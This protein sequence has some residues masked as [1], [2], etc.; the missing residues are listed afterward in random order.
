MSTNKNL[1]EEIGVSPELAQILTGHE[2]TEPTPIQEQGIPAILKGDDVLGVAKT[3]TGKTLA[4]VLPLIQMLHAKKSKNTATVLI[5]LPTRELAAQIQETFKWFEKL[6]RIYSV[7]IVG[8]ASVGRQ[9]Q[10]LK[11]KPQ[12]V[13]GTPGRLNDLLNQKKLNFDNIEHIVLDEADRMFDMGFE[14]QIKEMLQYAPPPQERQT[15]LFSATMADAVIDLIKNYMREPVHIEVAAH[16]STADNVRHEIVVLDSAHRIDALLEMV[17]RTKGA[18]L[19]FSRTK[20]QAKKINQLLRAKGHKSEELHGNL[21]LPRRKAAVAALQSKKSRIL[22]ATDIAARGIDISH[23][24]MVINYDLPDNPDDYIHRIGRTGR[25]GRKGY[26]ISFVCTNQAS[27]L[28]AIQKLINIQ[29]EH[30]RLESVPSAELKK[31]SSSKGGRRGGYKGGGGRSGGGSRGGYRGGGGT[32]TRRS[33]GNSRSRSTSSGRR[34]S[35]GGNSRSSSRS[36]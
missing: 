24:E 3:G 5:V 23:I 14:P 16:G 28:Q 32:S 26:A 4:F 15:L 36:R 31:G 35:G 12:V 6:F 25:A 22:V 30:T 19:V 33:G 13:I 1:F 9:L 18:I 10:E 8:G 7:V 29:I 21:S 20:F 34:S 11:R 27:E 2:I 17:N